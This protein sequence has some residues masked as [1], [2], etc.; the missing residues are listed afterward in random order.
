MVVAG[1]SGG[2][3]D[4]NKS[5]YITPFVNL[6]FSG[7]SL[8]N[9]NLVNNESYCSEIEK[10]GYEDELNSCCNMALMDAQ[11]KS[12]HKKWCILD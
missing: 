8:K 6:G 12:M 3:E 11:L 10:N 2:G 7:L 5:N 9:Y 4:E 1:S